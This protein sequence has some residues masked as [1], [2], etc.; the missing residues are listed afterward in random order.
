MHENILGQIKINK[1]AS[2]IKGTKNNFSIAVVAD[3]HDRMPGEVIEIL[4]KE[5]PDVIV[6]PG[7]TFVRHNPKTAGSTLKDMHDWQQS[8]LLWRITCKWIKLFSDLFGFT[9]RKRTEYDVSNGWALIIAASKIVPTFVSL[10]NHEWYLTEEDKELFNKTGATLLDNTHTTIMVKGNK[11]SFGGLSTKYDLDWLNKFS[12][13]E[14][15]KILLCHHPEYYERYIKGKDV[16]TVDIIISGHAHGGQWRLFDRGL[17]APGQGILPKYTKGI[18]GKMLVS[19]GLSN[20]AIVP[21]IN[22]PKEVVF[23]ECYGK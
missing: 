6:L 3:L 23:V 20:T 15:V 13:I 8:T 9:E 2:Q 16:D 1:Y 14:G 18:Y 10:G 11:V 17:F 12:K 22:N 4:G 19:A 7:D 5:R 21:R